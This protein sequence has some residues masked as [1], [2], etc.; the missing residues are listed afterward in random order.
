[1]LKYLEPDGVSAFS[2]NSVAC[3]FTIDFQT[4]SSLP[5]PKLSDDVLQYWRE[6]EKDLPIFAKIAKSALCVV[7]SSVASE[8]LFS[9]TEYTVADQ[10]ARLLPLH[11]QELSYIKYNF[12]IARERGLL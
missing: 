1:M 4:Y 3:R 6:R 12:Q 7:G 9:E 8:Q 11:V 2:S 5:R 10:R